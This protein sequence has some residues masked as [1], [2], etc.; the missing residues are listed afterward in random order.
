MQVGSHYSYDIGTTLYPARN[1]MRTDAANEKENTSVSADK[2]AKENKTPNELSPQEQKMLT[3][4][5]TR[6]AE[7]RQHEAAH[8][9][10][11]AP[12]GAASYTYQKGPDGQ[13]Y[14][15]GGEVSVSM[16]SG[17]TPEETIANAQAVIS[18]AM[19][20]ANPS[21]QDHA[22]ASSARVMM[23]K[24]EQQKAKELYEEAMGSNTYK[25]EE[26]QKDSESKIDLQ[27]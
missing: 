18:S 25:D 2:D 19:A 23:M 11:G 4:L 5:K 27:V 8:K 26:E 17:S 24:A 20:P 21:P 7:V 14:A 15:I 16:K 10:G 3:E 1:D 6:D 12:T 22:V 13:M 9:A